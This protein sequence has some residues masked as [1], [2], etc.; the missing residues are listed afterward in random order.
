MRQCGKC[1]SR[2]SGASLKPDTPNFQC[3]DTFGWA[4][5]R[6]SGPW[7]TVPLIPKGSVPEHLQEGNQ[8]QT[9][10]T[11]VELE[12]ALKWWCWSTPL[13][14][15]K[16]TGGWVCWTEQGWPCA[17]HSPGICMLWWSVRCADL[18]CV[19]HCPSTVPL[20]NPHCVWWN[21]CY[22]TVGTTLAGVI[23]QHSLN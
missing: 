22:I 16:W 5:R 12:I 9:R 19:A 3:I 8:G 13:T 15:Q 20:M 7:K 21:E 17:T 2:S 23:M 4:A 18:T 6:A 1:E 14:S 10:L 11:Q